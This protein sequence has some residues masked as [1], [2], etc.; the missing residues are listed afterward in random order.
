V[1]FQVQVASELELRPQP[2][3]SERI[4]ARWLLRM[5]IIL[6]SILHV[7]VPLTFLC[8]LKTVALHTPKIAFE[9]PG[10]RRSEP[11]QELLSGLDPDRT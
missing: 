10:G 4:R 5:E 6:P 1:N 7:S 11:A 9:S 8:H 2:L 3:L